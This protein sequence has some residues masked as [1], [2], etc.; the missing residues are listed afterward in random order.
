MLGNTASQIVPQ[1]EKNKVQFEARF[2]DSG[3]KADV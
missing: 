1:V 2:P 3:A